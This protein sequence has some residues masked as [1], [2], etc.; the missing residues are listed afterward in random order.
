MTTQPNNNRQLPDGWQWLRL[1]RIC[2]V[3]KQQI[4][5]NSP[6]FDSLP[7][8]GLEHIESNSGQIL[9][10]V[11][12]DAVESIG[13][14]F[15]YDTRH[16]LYGRLR[17]YLNK[18]ALPEKDGRCSTEIIPLLPEENIDR[19]YLAYLLRQPEIVATAARHST[20]GR[21][22]RADM[23]RLLELFVPVAPPKIQSSIA[24]K[25]DEEFLGV[26]KIRAAME[27]QQE[28]GTAMIGALS[29]EIFESKEA[30]HWERKELKKLTEKIGSGLTPEGGQNIYQSD[31]VPLIRSMNVHNNRFVTKGLAYISPE[32]DERMNN[33]R[34]QPGDVLL[35]ITGAS[36]GRAC[37][38]PDEICP[39]NVNQHV[40]IIRPI[41]DLLD[42]AFLSFTI[43][44]PKFQRSILS[45]QAG[46]TRQALTKA[47]IKGFEIP[48]PSPLE[49]R[50]IV[51]WLN[52]KLSDAERLKAA[53][54]RQLEAINAFPAIV[55]REVFG[56]LVPPQ[57]I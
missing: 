22:P 20:G 46:A 7:Y 18:V 3:D 48:L 40:S 21:M 55:L 11:I 36:I 57:A 12:A 53:T 15:R 43:T 16:V 35:N 51:S 19:R 45:S 39:A 9:T 56:E 52:E 30:E 23:K 26:T 47:Q 4:T 6:S 54:A 28:A 37:V 38:V 24:D 27:R 49:Q 14:A 42:P 5:P 1:S 25:I 44:Q 41:P 2:R 33:S 29:R 50:R 32:I 8:L 17:P 10:S 31:G 13:T 34:V